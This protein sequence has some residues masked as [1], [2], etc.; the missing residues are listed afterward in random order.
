MNSKSL[1]FKLAKRAAKLAVSYEVVQMAGRMER[2]RERVLSKENKEPKVFAS[3]TKYEYVFYKEAVEQVIRVVSGLVE[4]LISNAILVDEQLYNETREILDLMNWLID[5][6]KEE[7]NGT[8][9]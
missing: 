3:N 9:A 6:T 2:E 5:T 1:G 4:P 8:E 7:D